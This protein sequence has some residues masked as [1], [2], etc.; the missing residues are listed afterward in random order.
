[1]KARAHP[2]PST[3]GVN[4][5]TRTIRVRPLSPQVL[6]VSERFSPSAPV[7]RLLLN[8]VN[9]TVQRHRRLANVCPRKYALLDNVEHAVPRRDYLP[10]CLGGVKHAQH[11]GRRW[12]PVLANSSPHE[13]TNEHDKRQQAYL[14]YT[15]STYIY[16][17]ATL[18][19]Y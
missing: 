18:L 12:P 1:M 17:H 19:P 4:S 13:L 6:V 5:S 14:P 8:C 15:P 11:D 7:A 9:G 3:R 16:S 2:Q 10:S